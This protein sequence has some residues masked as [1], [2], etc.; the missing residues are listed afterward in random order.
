MPKRKTIDPIYEEVEAFLLSTPEESGE[1]YELWLSLWEKHFAGEKMATSEV[2]WAYWM[3]TTGA[4]CAFQQGDY[5][6]ALGY[7]DSFLAHP[8]VIQSDITTLTC[9]RSDRMMCLFHLRREA[10]AI[11][12]GSYLL[13]FERRSDI[14]TALLLMRNGLYPFL[15]QAE[16]HQSASVDLTEF[17]WKVAQGIHYRKRRALPSPATFGQLSASLNQTWPRADREEV[18]NHHKS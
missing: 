17:V 8:N 13:T 15:R 9:L 2:G 4:R 11:A 7:T 16:L 3:T 18:E 1:K 12:L 10:E 14:R 6:T 5:L